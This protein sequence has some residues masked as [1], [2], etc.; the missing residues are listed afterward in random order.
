MGLVKPLGSLVGGIGGG[1]GSGVT[2]SGI[3]KPA[4]AAGPISLSGS[5]FVT[6]QTIKRQCIAMLYGDAGL[7]KTTAGLLAAP[8]PVALIN[9]DGR[10]EWAVKHAESQGRRIH[11]LKVR[12][13]VG[14]MRMPDEKAAAA[15]KESVDKIVRN[16]EAAIVASE[17]GDVRTIVIDTGT[18][19]A[20]YLTIRYRGNQRGAP[21]DYGK[22]KDLMNRQWAALFD[23]VRAS[24]AHLIVLSRARA[25]WEDNEPTSE[26]E[27][28]VPD[29]VR[30]NVDWAAH[31]RPR[32]ALPGLVMG[33]PTTA[34]N[35]V[36]VG[37]LVKPSGLV[38]TGAAKKGSSRLSKEREWQ[39]TK[40]GNNGPELGA[41][42]TQDQWGENGEYGN[43]GP[44]VY[45]CCRMYPGTVPE[46][47]R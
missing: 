34:T 25:I 6:L 27:P 3:V 17:R 1:V 28:R 47:W 36:K 12:L 32:K 10:A 44:F 24:K 14:I 11:Y 38:P 33:V 22:S 43:V 21:K 4:P 29:V 35:P 46:D 37:G 19:F 16:A 42:Y 45:A 23:D 26:F 31:I 15:A 13:P 20:E 8:S 9:L 39:V 7:G 30:D 5:D 18:E 2:G 40:A 41:I